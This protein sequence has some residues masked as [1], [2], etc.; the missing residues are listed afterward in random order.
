MKICKELLTNT[1]YASYNNRVVKIDPTPPP[2]RIDKKGGEN[3][4]HQTYDAR[5]Q[6]H[7]RQMFSIIE[8]MIWDAVEM[9]DQT[10]AAAA[11][12]D[13]EVL[14]IAE[15]VQ[16]YAEKYGE[17]VK[18]NALNRK[19]LWDGEKQIWILKSHLGYSPTSPDDI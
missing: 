6:A 5:Q 7:T 17:L 16:I 13:E 19:A 18:A 11:R 8:N 10:N 3:V 9:D 12:V 2:R 4:K 15:N 1:Y 14:H